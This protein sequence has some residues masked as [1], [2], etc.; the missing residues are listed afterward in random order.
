[1]AKALVDSTRDL[2]EQNQNKAFK[3]TAFQI[4]VYQY[5]GGYNIYCEMFS[6]KVT[7]VNIGDFDA[8]QVL[9]QMGHDSCTPTD[10]VKISCQFIS[11]VGKMGLATILPQF[12]QND[13]KNHQKG[14]ITIPFAG[15][16]FTLNFEFE[17]L[18]EYAPGDLDKKAIDIFREK[19]GR[20]P[21]DQILSDSKFIPVFKVSGV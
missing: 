13:L 8:R 5:V 17:A 14:K 16:T 15:F 20:D 9:V 1:M 3:L 19:N 12:D 21:T 11:K 7:V 2:A 10:L 4:P 18:P 6:L